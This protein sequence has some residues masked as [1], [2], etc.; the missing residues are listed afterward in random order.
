V[1]RPR[2]PACQCYHTTRQCTPWNIRRC[3]KC[4]A[5][6]PTP[7]SQPSCAS[8]RG[9]RHTPPATT[10]ACLYVPV[11]SRLYR[12]LPACWT[13]SAP[14]QTLASAPAKQATY[15][16]HL[17]VICVAVAAAPFRVRSIFPASANT[18]QTERCSQ[19]EV[20]L[21]G[22]ARATYRPGS[23]CSSEQVK[24]SPDVLQT[25][26]QSSGL[27]G[28]AAMQ[29]DGTL[30]QRRKIHTDHPPALAAPR[31]PYC[32]CNKAGGL[33]WFHS[34]HAAHFYISSDVADGVSIPGICDRGEHHNHPCR[35]C[36]SSRGFSLRTLQAAAICAHGC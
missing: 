10:G 31:K 18:Q 3:C 16:R 9:S 34:D 23:P 35:Y 25:V 12:Y 28:P 14:S 33:K 36:N 24:A 26:V 15:A 19:P 13:A 20:P 30:L 2:H 11:A 8:A 21:T 7:T 32:S 17:R 1:L 5:I 29:Q 4:C 27:L 22:S 6:R